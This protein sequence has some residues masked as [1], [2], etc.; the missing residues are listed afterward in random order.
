MKLLIPQADVSKYL[1]S[2]TCK[3]IFGSYSIDMTFLSSISDDRLQWVLHSFY[4]SFLRSSSKVFIMISQCSSERLHY[5]CWGARSVFCLCFSPPKSPSPMG[6]P[7]LFGFAA[8]SWSRLQTPP[9]ATPPEQRTAETDE[10]SSMAV[11]QPRSCRLGLSVHLVFFPGSH[12]GRSASAS[13]WPSL[14]VCRVAVLHQ[15]PT[16]SHGTHN[17]ISFFCGNK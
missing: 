8:C 4:V 12:T 6:H 1:V 3:K 17:V 16:S 10:D 15:P 2:S 13:A 7:C 14:A 9:I 5:E 11:F